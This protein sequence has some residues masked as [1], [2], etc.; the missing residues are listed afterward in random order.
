MNED[1]KTINKNVKV[2]YHAKQ[3]SDIEKEIL[4]N[5]GD[6]LL[7]KGLITELESKKYRFLV[8]RAI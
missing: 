8:D 4:L 3:T 6:Y 5:I 1:V 7:K 2:A